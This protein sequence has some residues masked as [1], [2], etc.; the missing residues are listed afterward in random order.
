MDCFSKRNTSR[1]SFAA[2]LRLGLS[3]ASFGL[4]VAL[5]AWTVSIAPFA[6]SA[7]TTNPVADLSGY[8]ARS[9]PGRYA[10]LFDPPDRGPGPIVFSAEAG[11]DRQGMPFMGDDTN[12]ILLP[13]A[14]EAVR[15][16]RDAYRRGEAVYSAWALCMPAGLPVAFSMIN[17]VQFL[18]EENEVT[19]IYQRGQ[20]IRHVYLGEQHPDDLKPTW[21][22]HSVGHYEGSDTLVIDTVAQDTRAITDRFGTPKSEAMRVV[23][24][25]T[26]AEDGQRLD[27]EFYV[28][29]PLTFALAWSAKFSYPRVF[30]RTGQ[31]Q[32]PIFAEIVCPENTRDATG[33]ERSIPIA[34]D[35]DF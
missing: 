12:P 29:D 22:G 30:P 20:T 7:E 17:A 31:G 15:A 26:V 10:A 8:W 13:H 9:G 19:I 18:Q 6:K 34:T 5:A 16:Q 23:E 35:F 32:E 1:P 28:E 11:E 3:I 25:Y 24:R 4:V 21:F 2:Q 27:V 14:A 33:E